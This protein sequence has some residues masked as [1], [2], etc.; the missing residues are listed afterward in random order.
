LGKQ[1]FG[2]NKTK[3]KQEGSA[4]GEQTSRSNALSG[5]PEWGGGQVKTNCG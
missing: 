4:G 5:F 1:L 3:E 2:T